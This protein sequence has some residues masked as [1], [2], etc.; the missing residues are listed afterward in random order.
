RPGA[1]VLVRGTLR[2]SLDHVPWLDFFPTAQPV[3]ERQMPSR[4]DVIRMF[5]G[6]GFCLLA[7]EVV[8]QECG[9]SL[10]AY[11][12][13]IRMRAISTLELISDA[14]FERGIARMREAAEREKK[15]RP[16]MEHIDLVVFRR[17][18]DPRS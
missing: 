7:S 8:D 9:A 18:Q 10:G 4:D 12:E 16:V 17:D 2:D 1:V 5:D 6:Q 15:P 13:R 3:A 11:Y 14:E